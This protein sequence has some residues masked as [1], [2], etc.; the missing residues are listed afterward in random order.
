MSEEIKNQDTEQ[1]EKP[2][3]VLYYLIG[4]LGVFAYNANAIG[5]NIS[6][7]DGYIW[8]ILGAV[9]NIGIFA[10]FPF[11]LANVA[12]SY[13]APTFNFKHLYKILGFALLV[14]V[15]AIAF[16]SGCAG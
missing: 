8:V 14:I 4:A 7:G 3:K 16:V 12:E 11:A 6:I 10:W 2:S 9:V 1:N 5:N 13:K 15:F